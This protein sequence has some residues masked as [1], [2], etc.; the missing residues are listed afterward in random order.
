MAIGQES[1]AARYQ[2]LRPI[3]FKT[4]DELNGYLARLDAEKAAAAK[5]RDAR[6]KAADD[7]YKFSQLD[8]PDTKYKWREVTSKL[9]EGLSQDLVGL[10][11]KRNNAFE[12]GNMSEYNKTFAEESNI[13]SKLPN[14]KMAFD[15]FEQAQNDL[16]EGINKGDYS[17]T[18][19]ADLLANLT[20]IMQG[21]WDYDPNKEEFIF[22]NARDGSK[23]KRN[24]Q[25]MTMN[26]YL[27]E[28]PKQFVDYNKWIT[29]TAKNIGTDETVWESPD[30]VVTRIKDI[31]DVNTMRQA[32]GEMI[33]AD[34][35]LLE[36]YEAGSNALNAPSNDMKTRED[37]I[38]EVID[39]AG[40][41]ADTIESTRIETPPKGDGKKTVAE[42]IIPT[43][44]SNA[45]IFDSDGQPTTWQN[46]TR[47]AISMTVAVKG[48][49]NISPGRAAVSSRDKANFDYEAANG[50][51]IPV[52]SREMREWNEV[53]TGFETNLI[54]EERVYQGPTVF[55][56][57]LNKD[58]E[59]PEEYAA[60]DNPWEAFVAAESGRFG[61]IE[62]YTTGFFLKPG[63]YYPQGF[64]DDV[65][66]GSI[67]VYNVKDDGG[68]LES[69]NIQSTTIPA[70]ELLNNSQ[71]RTVMKGTDS[72]GYQYD[73]PAGP[74]NAEFFI[75]VDGESK[76][77]L[78][79]YL[80]ALGKD[81]G[82][83]IVDSKKYGEMSGMTEEE[84][85]RLIIEGKLP[86]PTQRTEP[87]TVEQKVE[88][89]E[90]VV[91]SYPEA[92]QS[93]IKAFAKKNNLAEDEA[94]KVLTDNGII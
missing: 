82:G 81:F 41:F 73:I 21:S 23:I 52:K 45:T 55:I 69:G 28:T 46:P 93:K 35:N 48:D 64:I 67:S 74:E 16:A 37:L 32:V 7:I 18:R 86:G 39:A 44:T 91:S 38:D 63:Q 2:R 3:E 53:I 66:R 30:G 34:P 5:A 68:D 88:R 1:T 84:V 65:A 25:Q 50:D 43:T 89:A 10:W 42:S 83:G 87:K 17:Q 62:D 27:F 36:E 11:Q 31:K 92:T 47:N 61:D 14:Y 9:H 75:A 22:E 19:N 72:S 58:A 94:I 71:Y 78:S 12:A 56:R 59:L 85:D 54:T 33:D 20:G 4:G 6:K 80:Q 79:E 24:L 70:D 8:L 60:A 90:D 26:P 57:G 40:L 29:D 49:V 13:R 77:Q 51:V 76:R 15:A